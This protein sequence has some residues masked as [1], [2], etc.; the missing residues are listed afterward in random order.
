MELLFATS[1]HHKVKEAN[2]VAAGFGLEFE[3]VNVLYPEVRADAVGRVAE[4]GAKYVYN[5]MK[6]PIIVEDSGLF[7][8]A[9]DGFPGA[10]SAYVFHKLGCAGILKLMDGAADRKAR[11]V[12]A[13]GYCDRR[14]VKVFEG[15]VEGFIAGEARGSEGFGYDPL[16][17]P[18]DSPKTFAEDPKH[19]GEV[20]HRRK[21][22]EQ[23]CR[24]LKTL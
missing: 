5:Q 17:K 12:S 4:E 7:I 16:F 3:Q 8:D 13:I 10:Y 1:N 18:H 23:L 6:K 9:F 24:Y 14:G 11:F 21:A 20:S 2:A 15:V 22:T 19:K